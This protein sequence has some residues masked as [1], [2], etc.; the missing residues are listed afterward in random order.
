[1]AC[2][3]PVIASR[4][5][6]GREAVLQGEIGQIVDPYDKDELEQAIYKGL[7]QGRGIPPQLSHFTYRNFRDRVQQALW[8]VMAGSDSV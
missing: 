2:G 4:I 5:D 1:M 6:G 3:I 8:P 7:E